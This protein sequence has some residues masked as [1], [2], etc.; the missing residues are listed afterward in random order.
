MVTGECGGCS[1]AEC[2]KEK[3][4]EI[5]TAAWGIVTA[6]AKPGLSSFW[7]RAE[8]WSM[9]D[10][11]QTV[12]GD[13]VASLPYG[14]STISEFEVA[15]YEHHYS[16]RSWADQGDASLVAD[17]GG[18]PGDSLN[19]QKS[20]VDAGAFGAPFVLSEPGAGVPRDDPEDP[21]DEPRFPM[22]E[23]PPE[24]PP[25]PPDRPRGGSRL[26]CCYY[27]SI[28][29]RYYKLPPGAP[30]AEGR[31]D[32][33]HLQIDVSYIW[34]WA[35]MYRPCLFKWEERTNA[36][37]EVPPFPEPAPDGRILVPAGPDGQKGPWVDV[38][39]EAVRQSAKDKMQHIDVGRERC[40][41]VTRHGPY[42]TLFHD[43]PLG[44]P[45]KQ[46]IRVSFTTGCGGARVVNRNAVLP[47][48]HNVDSGGNQRIR[49]ETGP[50]GSRE[51]EWPRP[52]R[53]R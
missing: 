39:R 42:F 21:P 24:G 5:D 4:E 37:Y 36:S 26:C 8:T 52:G 13:H 7:Q 30:K 28:T 33:A 31:R 50:R 16:R 14:A 34:S 41:E 53:R 15:T 18:P 12:P 49:P 32:V 46:D 9:V 29:Y 38:S 23:D 44:G 6:A 3:S 22:P 11:L 51:V 1:C 10:S 25:V 48:E 43:W 20:L 35:P 27:E 45:K 19:E 40:D 17:V 2:G 47:F